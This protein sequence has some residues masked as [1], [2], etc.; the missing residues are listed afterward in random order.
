[1]AESSSGVKQLAHRSAQALHLRHVP[2]R[3]VGVGGKEEIAFKSK[4]QEL[5]DRLVVL[6]SP[7]PVPHSEKNLIESGRRLPPP[8]IGH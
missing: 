5:F 7:E 4:A 8:L 3:D 6:R 2:D 1:M